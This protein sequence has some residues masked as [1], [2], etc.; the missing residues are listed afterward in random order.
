M[1]FLCCC[2]FPF[3]SFTKRYAGL[4]RHVRLVRSNALSII[5]DGL[6]GYS[7]LSS[8]SGSNAKL[9]AGDAVFHASAELG[10]L[11][12]TEQSGVTVK[13]TLVDK[14]VSTWL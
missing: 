9:V 12:S 11:G 10:N 6:F 2:F 14:E 5:P 1:N 13:F 3:L 8:I 7:N 4:Y